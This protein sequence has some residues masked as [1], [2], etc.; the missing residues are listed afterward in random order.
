M[1]L[2]DKQKKAVITA[3]ILIVPFG[4]SVALLYQTY[5]KVKEKDGFKRFTQYFS[6]KKNE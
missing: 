4:L 1:Q 6:I 3:L 2:T 5:K